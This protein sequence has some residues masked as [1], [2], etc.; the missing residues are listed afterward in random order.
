MN[1][2][3]LLNQT[4]L[5]RSDGWKICEQLLLCRIFGLCYQVVLIEFFAPLPASLH[6][7]TQTIRH[8]GDN[9]KDV[10]IDAGRRR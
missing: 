4:T 9:L 1:S 10:V 8:L 2:N 3:Q 5:I 6:S 7:S